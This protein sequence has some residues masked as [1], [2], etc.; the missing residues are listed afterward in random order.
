[1]AARGGPGHTLHPVLPEA[2]LQR[3]QAAVEAARERQADRAAAAGPEPISRQASGV[4][5]TGTPVDIW[6]P[7][8][9][10]AAATASATGQAKPQPPD[11]PAP[12][13]Q[14]PDWPAPQPLTPE[15]PPAQPSP[16]TPEPPPVPEAQLGSESQL[17]LQSQPPT[18]EAQ[19][20]S[21]PD[22]A[23]Q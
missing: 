23:L 9:T 1:G 8:R 18:L 12:K 17:T 19:L 4:T 16:P 11:W 21:E 6:P 7:P 13:P 2:L 3:M 20:A 10:T 5:H 14:A 22:L 15:W